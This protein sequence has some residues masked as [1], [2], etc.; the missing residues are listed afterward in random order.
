MSDNLRCNQSTFNDSNKKQRTA[1]EW[2]IKHPIPDSEFDLLFL[3]F[4][5]THLLKNIWNNWETEK[6]QTLRFIDSGTSKTEA[7]WLKSRRLNY[8]SLYPTNFEKQVYLAL[9]I[10]NE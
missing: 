9:N 8:S 5:P 1:K 10:L 7:H 6:T 2:F 3:L 4:D